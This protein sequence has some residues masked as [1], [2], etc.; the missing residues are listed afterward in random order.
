[1][2]LTS[3]RNWI[4]FLRIAPWGLGWPGPLEDIG[5]RAWQQGLY[6]QN[7]VAGS[8]DT[9]P[10]LELG[11]GHFTDWFGK[12]SINWADDC[13]IKSLHSFRTYS[14]F[15]LSDFLGLFIYL[16]LEIKLLPFFFFFLVKPSNHLP[17]PFVFCFYI[18]ANL[19]PSPPR[20]LLKFKH[21]EATPDLWL[22]ISNKFVVKK[23]KILTDLKSSLPFAL[24]ALHSWDKP[25]S[26]HSPGAQAQSR[27]CFSLAPSS[28]L[29]RKATT[30]PQHLPPP[31]AKPFTAH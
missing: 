6:W 28:K 19:M 22:S 1:M 25:I 2:L 9:R 31:P 16:A 8:R 27:V 21:A 17:L 11:S 30:L 23:I 3:K 5:R 4:G 26:I 15:L 13:C 24:L 20:T 18:F 14:Y 10:W 12:G 29:W 7:T